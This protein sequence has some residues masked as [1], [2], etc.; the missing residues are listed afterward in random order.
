MINMNYRLFKAFVY[1]VLMVWLL[2]ACNSQTRYH[3]FRHIDEQRWSHAETIRFDVPL[4]DSLHNHK[5]TLY[6]S[7]LTIY[8]DR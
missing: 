5:I 8:K 3:Q 4:T 6:I 2:D 7:R 1:Y